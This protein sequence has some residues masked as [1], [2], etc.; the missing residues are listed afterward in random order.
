MRGDL[1]SDSYVLLASCSAC[2]YKCVN[3]SGCE[4]ANASRRFENA[5]KTT[6][7]QEIERGERERELNRESQWCRCEFAN[8]RGQLNAVRAV[9]EHSTR[10]PCY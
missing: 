3:R 9:T 6:G 5:D 4:C 1:R 7:K 10:I 2:V 8:E